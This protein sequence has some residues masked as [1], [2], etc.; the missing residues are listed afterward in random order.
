[1]MISNFFELNM[2]SQPKT[3]SL[4]AKQGPSKHPSALE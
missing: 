1:V 3:K 2:T 4:Q